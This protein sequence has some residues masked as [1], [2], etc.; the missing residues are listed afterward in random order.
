[1]DR[2][3][4]THGEL[5]PSGTAVRTSRATFTFYTSQEALPLGVGKSARSLVLAVRDLGM[6]VDPELGHISTAHD[7]KVITGP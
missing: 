5:A 2:A 1:M 6:L 7:R 3:T 4:E